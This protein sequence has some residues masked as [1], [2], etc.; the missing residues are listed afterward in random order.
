MKKGILII[1]V[2]IIA[3]ITI[4]IISSMLFKYHEAKILCNQIKY[5][6][7]ID[8]DFSNGTTS[9]LFFDKIASIMQIDGP[10]IPLVEACYYRNVQAVKVLLENGA[11]PNFYIHG[12]WTALEATI[13]SSPAGL[14]D[15]RSFEIIKLL[16]EYG[17]N[18]D[19][20]SSLDPIVEQLSS[21]VSLG[22][23]PF[24]EFRTEVLLYLLDNTENYNDFNIVFYDAARGGNVEL[25]K[26]VLDNY[27][28]DINYKR[29]FGRTPLIGV[30][31]YPLAANVTEMIS[32]LLEHG[33][34]KNLADDNGKT[35]Y[36]YAVETGNQEIIDLL[37]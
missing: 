29:H 17:A 16:V 7:E 14:M 30:V 3:L 15:K 35:A 33:A 1:T 23:E 21:W 32:I 11:D 10:K 37:S 34:D 12:R 5:G 31:S 27:A 24:N 22:G 6:E 13:V 8:T 2:I 28:V 26:I 20:S 4:L 25:V 9:P 19:K 36:D 18:L